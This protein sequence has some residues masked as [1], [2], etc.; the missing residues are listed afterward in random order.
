MYVSYQ[1]RTKEEILA[2]RDEVL[3]ELLTI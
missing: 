2:S 3:V 1:H